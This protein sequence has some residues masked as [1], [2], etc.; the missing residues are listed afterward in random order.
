MRKIAS[1]VAAASPR[2]DPVSRRREETTIAHEV[3]LA[4][5]YAKLKGPQPEVRDSFTSSHAAKYV[6]QGLRQSFCDPFDVYERHISNASLDSAVIRSM[7]TASVGKLFLRPMLVEGGRRGYR[8]DSEKRYP[9]KNK[10][11]AKKNPHPKSLGIRAPVLWSSQGVARGYRSQA[12]GE[13]HAPGCS[14][15]HP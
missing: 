5:S 9:K 2:L 15:R 14:Q 11:I 8:D 7:Q 6:R 3:N 1:L 12:G 13:A 10:T 4:P